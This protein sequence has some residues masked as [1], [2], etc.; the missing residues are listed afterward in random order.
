MQRYDIPLLVEAANSIKVNQG[1][2]ISMT[3]MLYIPSMVYSVG[4]NVC[5]IPL[6]ALRGA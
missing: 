4:L 5:S 1:K 3:L 6:E 2:V